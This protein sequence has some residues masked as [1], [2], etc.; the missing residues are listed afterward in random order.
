ML[1]GDAALAGFYINE[2]CLRL[3]PR[4]APQPELYAVYAQVR[5]RLRAGESLAWTLRRFE[6]DVLDA[7]GVGLDYALA[8]EG[9]MD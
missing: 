9:A 1:H 8:G 3:A 5:E 4:Q 6:R 2:L 7:L